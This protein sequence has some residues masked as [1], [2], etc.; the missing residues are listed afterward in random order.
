MSYKFEIG[1]ANAIAN[2]EFFNNFNPDED[3][4]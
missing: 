1:C 3:D 4:V 2:F